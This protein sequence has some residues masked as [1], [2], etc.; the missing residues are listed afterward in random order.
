LIFFTKLAQAG[1]EAGDAKAARA[2]LEGQ[3]AAAAFMPWT[4]Q[5]L[6]LKWPSVMTRHEVAQVAP[7]AEAARLGTADTAGAGIAPNHIHS[8]DPH[9]S[10]TTADP[11]AMAARVAPAATAAREVP[12]GPGPVVAFISRAALL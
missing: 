4:G 12:V 7:A 3:G 8:D 5:S 2:A 6:C 1:T 9:T 10:D 11:G